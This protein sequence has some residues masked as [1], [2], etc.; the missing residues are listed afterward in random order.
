MHDIGEL[1]TALEANFDI[2][3]SDI[4]YQDVLSLVNQVDNKILAR[5]FGEVW[6][7]ETKK[8]KYSGLSLID[9][10]NALKPKKVIDIGCGYNEFKGKIDNLIGIDPYNKKADITSSII[11][12]ETTE[13]YD[14]AICL[15]SINFGSVNKIYDELTKVVSI[16]NK[17]GLIF[18]RVNPGEQHKKEEATWINFFEWTPEFIMNAA[19]SL[20]CTVEKLRM[21]VGNRYYFV[22]RK[23]K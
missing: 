19:K 11:D 5:Y 14:V 22:L 16:V 23:D 9:Q 20:D 17:D 15:G 2:D 13:K 18:F 6:Q 21:D 10:I 7:P 3:A 8:Y 4:V 1:R 12:Y